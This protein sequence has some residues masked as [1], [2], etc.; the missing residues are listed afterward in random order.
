MRHNSTYITH[1]EKW[2]NIH[3]ALVV[4]L[5]GI[6]PTGI[7]ISEKMPNFEAL[8]TDFLCDLY[9]NVGFPENAVQ[10]TCCWK[11]EKL[12]DKTAHRR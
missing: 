1:L 12:L 10:V 4:T 6:I 11:W 3:K 7:Y 5:S 2:R 8:Y 9:Q